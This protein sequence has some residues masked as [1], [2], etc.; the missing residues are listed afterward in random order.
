MKC[1]TATDALCGFSDPVG[2]SPLHVW[3]DIVLHVVALAVALGMLESCF[4]AIFF[5]GLMREVTTAGIGA[6]LAP[7]VPT[8]RCPLNFVANSAKFLF[9]AEVFIATLSWS[10]AHRCWFDDFH[11]ANLALS[12]NIGWFVMHSAKSR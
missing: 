4:A 7:L 1:F 2:V 6:F 5:T 8:V 9:P 11:P 10:P 12:D 3:D